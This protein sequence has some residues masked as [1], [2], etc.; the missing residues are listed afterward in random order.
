[1]AEIEK[2]LK[3]LMFMKGEYNQ[4]ELVVKRAILLKVF[5]ESKLLEKRSD[6]H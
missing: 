2:S 6:V 4:E 5:L 1:M 3:W